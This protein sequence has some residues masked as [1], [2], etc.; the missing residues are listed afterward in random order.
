MISLF[1]P[2]TWTTWYNSDL[3]LVTYPFPSIVLFLAFLSLSKKKKIF[4]S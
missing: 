4:N 1:V 2:V 3:V